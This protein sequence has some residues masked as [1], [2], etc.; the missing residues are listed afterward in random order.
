[1]PSIVQAKL[2]LRSI[3]M[4]PIRGPLSYSINPAENAIRSARLAV[5]SSRKQPQ[6]EPVG[7]FN[8]S[9]SRR[10]STENGEIANA[11]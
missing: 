8:Q 1:M 11:V 6:G 3:G 2:D 4:L 10:P 7:K 9:Q 5:T